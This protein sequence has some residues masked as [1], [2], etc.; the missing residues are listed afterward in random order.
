LLLLPVALVVPG[1]LATLLS[2][3]V[4]AAVLAVRVT[5]VVLAVAGGLA[6]CWVSCVAGSC[7]PW[8]AGA[9]AGVGIDGRTGLELSSMQRLV[10]LE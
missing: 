10:A 4:L 6:H 2:V 7:R 1:L 9:G 8:R 5:L 3:A